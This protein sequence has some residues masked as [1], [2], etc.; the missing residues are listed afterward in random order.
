MTTLQDAL[1]DERFEGM[2]LLDGYDD[3]FIGVTDSKDGD[4]LSAVYVIDKIVEIL[5]QDMSYEDAWE[6]FQ[7]NVA[8]LYLGDQTPTFIRRKEA[9]V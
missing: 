7:Y 5:A 6:Y 2:F 1:S 3:A 8:G 9:L 4:L